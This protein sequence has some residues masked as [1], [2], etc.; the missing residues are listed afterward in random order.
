MN[1]REGTRR[2]ALL[3]GVAGLVF[4]GFVSYMEL[5]SVQDQRARHN[6]FEQLAA[7]DVVQQERKILKAWK[8]VPETAPDFLAGAKPVLLDF[9]RAKPIPGRD[10]TPPASHQQKIEGLPPGA[11]VRPMGDTGLPAGAIVKPIAQHPAGEDLPPGAT[12]AS[13]PQTATPQQPQADPY[14]AITIP[15][16]S[17]V[18]GGGIETI[19][20]SHNYGV[21]SIKTEDGQTL[22]PTVAPSAWL[23]LLIL[24]LP[25]LGFIIPWGTVRAIGWVGAG[26]VAGTK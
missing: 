2:L 21:A 18:N 23:Y 14:A 13:V 25:L 19:N 10:K 12:V 17:D 11:I 4:G 7:S 6:R 9:S 15:I 20:W 24:L 5:Q 8:P 1:L 16:P 22:Y 26:F 3:L